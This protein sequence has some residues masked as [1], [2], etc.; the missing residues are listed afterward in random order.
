MFYNHITGGRQVDLSLTYFWKT[1][2]ILF[3]RSMV[4]DMQFRDLDLRDFWINPA[5]GHF[6][7]IPTGVERALFRKLQMLSAAHSLQDLRIPPGHRLEKL[8][9]SRE[10]QYSIRVNSQWRLCFY[11]QDGEAEEVEVFEYH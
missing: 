9:G 6:Q 8:H 2:I 10:G 11:W 1:V 5:A 4:R 7:R 3:N